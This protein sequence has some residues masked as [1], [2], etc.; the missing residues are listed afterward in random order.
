[1]AETED[2][3]SAQ[4][5]DEVQSGNAP[6]SKAPDGSG[7]PEVSAAELARRQQQ[8]EQ[9][10]GKKTET[11]DV[12]SRLNFLEARELERVRDQHVTDF[13][14]SNAKDYPN[15]K[16]DDALF[17]YASS[18]DEV[19]E[20]AT[21]IQN[22]FMTMQQ[23]ALSSVQSEPETWLT[24]EEYAAREKELEETA[25]KTGKSQFGGFMD[26]LQRRKR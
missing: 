18:E 22:R 8:S 7:A 13:L 9:D 21:E 26:A 3:S 10:R 14:S 25:S 6:A 4:A 1:M 15:V 24:E 23:E 19:K 2:N 5:G 20:I 16:A 17:K 12:G 11:D